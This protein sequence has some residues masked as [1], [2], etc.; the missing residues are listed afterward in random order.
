M[1]PLL[2]AVV[3]SGSAF[4]IGCVGEGQ[5]LIEE[6]GNDLQRGITGQGSLY[7]QQQ[8]GDPFIE[9]SAR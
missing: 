1:K 8:S 3:L 5:P 4:L 7:E 2:F 6:A 9:D